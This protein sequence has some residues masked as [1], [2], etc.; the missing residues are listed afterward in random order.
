MKSYQ[1]Y[2]S[3]METM[4]SN[5]WAIGLVAAVV[6]TVLVTSF[7]VSVT[8]RPFVAVMTIVV[9]PALVVGIVVAWL[10]RRGDARR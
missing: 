10:F 5:S 4:R 3:S 1:D 8:A 9:P 2:R 6:T 7:I